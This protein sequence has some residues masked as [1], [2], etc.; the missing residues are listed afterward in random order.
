MVWEVPGIDF[1]KISGGSVL[2]GGD[3]ASQ[4]GRLSE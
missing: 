4:S 3:G 2:I 1:A